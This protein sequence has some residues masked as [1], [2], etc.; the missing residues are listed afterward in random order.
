M[1]KHLVSREGLVSAITDELNLTS[2]AKKSTGYFT[3]SQLVQILSAVKVLK[4]QLK[5]GRLKGN[6]S[7]TSEDK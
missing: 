6:N 4:N 3:R 2:V 1:G 5:Q 7:A